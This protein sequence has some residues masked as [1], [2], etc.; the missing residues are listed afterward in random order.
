MAFLGPNSNDPV[1]NLIDIQD[2]VLPQ[3][4]TVAARVLGLAVFVVLFI[5]GFQ[6]LTAAGDPKKVEQARATLTG[7]V[8]GL[9]ILIVGWYG[10]NLI[11]EVTGVPLTLLD[12]CF[13]KDCL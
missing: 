11:A 3:V 10:L 4:L 12:L 2:G 7:A 1:A 6:W 13:T 8:I 9:A 5:G